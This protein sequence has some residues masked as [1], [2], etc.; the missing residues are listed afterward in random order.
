M[1]DQILVNGMVWGRKEP[2]VAPIDYDVFAQ[3]IMEALRRDK[4][5]FRADSSH[6]IKAIVSRSGFE[7]QAPNLNDP[8]ETKWALLLP[9]RDQE[10]EAIA[11]ALDPLIQ[12]RKGQVIYSPASPGAAFPETWID[13]QYSQMNDI[14]RPYYVMLA[15]NLNAIPFR[16]QYLLDIQAAVGRLSFDRLDDYN[17]YAKKVVDFETQAMA[18][19]ARQALFFATEHDGDGATLVSRQHMTDPLVKMLRE[20]DI[21]VSYLA[22]AEATQMELLDRLK[23]DGIAPAPALVYTA[24]HGLGIP[25]SD[26]AAEATRR[27][28][29]GAL[30]CQDYDGRSGVFCADVVPETPFLHGSIVFSFACYGAGTPKQSDFFHWIRR[31][32]LLTCRPDIDFIA[33]LPKRLLAHPQGPLAFSGHLDPAWVYSFANP[34]QIAT[35]KGWGSRMGP[36][37][38]AV[39]HLLQGATIGYAMKRF[40]EVY[41]TLSAKLA[42]I[43]DNFLCN[44]SLGENK[45]WTRNLIDIWMTRNDTQ[46]FIV[47]GD[48]AVKAKMQ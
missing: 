23:G 13:E 16:F 21:P 22:G 6:G 2:L 14:D 20:K 7:F 31:P 27:K 11:A 47:L 18:H 33:A 40:N 43:E 4:E 32:E 28:L 37:R 17:K 25:G 24:S 9:P 42:C 39:G 45:Q 35:D 30:V 5:H 29:Q 38:Q 48:P 3:S 10:S 36:F 44:A 46:N 26:S 19:V 12:H 15:G 1:A 34:S 8:L 41:A